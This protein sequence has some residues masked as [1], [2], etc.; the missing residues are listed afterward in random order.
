MNGSWVGSI[1]K[2]NPHLALTGWR[3]SGVSQRIE[4]IQGVELF[5]LLIEVTPEFAHIFVVEA[6]RLLLIPNEHQIHYF[7]KWLI[8]LPHHPL[9]EEIQYSSQLQIW[10]SCG[11]WL[12]ELIEQGKFLPSVASKQENEREVG[13]ASLWEIPMGNAAIEHGVQA[14]TAA[15]N[16]AK[17]FQ[18]E[19]TY[20]SD[21]ISVSKTQ[22]ESF[23]QVCA[24]L[25]IRSHIGEQEV[26]Q[27]LYEMNPRFS[28]PLTPV[29]HWVHAL[30]TNPVARPV[31]SLDW[32]AQD[33]RQWTSEFVV[34]TQETAVR[35]CLRL[36][37]PS[38][39]GQGTW[40]LLFYLQAEHDPHIML[41]ASEIWMHPE[42]VIV[43]HHFRFVEPQERLL[44][45]LALAAERFV[46]LERSFKV[47]NPYQCELTLEEAFVFLS[48]GAQLLQQEGIMV[49]VP[50]W[51]KKRSTPWGV[52]LHLDQPK[53]SP[54]IRAPGE[55]LLGFQSLV[56]YDLGIAIGDMLLTPEELKEL[57]ELNAPLVKVRGEWIQ[58]HP[59]LAQQFLHRVHDSGNATISLADAMQ[60]ALESTQGEADAS[61]IG[62]GQLPITKVTATGSIG[63]LIEAWQGDTILYN[64]E[65]PAA[66]HGTLR[67][68]QRIGY[69]WL[70]AM[71]ELGL[72]ACLADD[73]GLGKTIQ[74]ISYIVGLKESVELQG[75]CLLV[76]PTS[77]LENWKRELQQFAPSLKV[78]LH[79]GPD[80][81][82]SKQLG[83]QW[84]DIDIVMTSYT[85]AQRDEAMLASI[86]WEVVTLDEAQNIKNT[87][88]KQ[89]QTI[90]KLHG[91]HRIALTG[92]PVENRLSELWSIMDFLN[93]DYLGTQEEFRVKFAM[94]IERNQ[95]EVITHTLSRIIQPFILR[96]VKS[97]QRVIQDLPE[98]LEM[99]EFCSLTKE[100]IGLYEATVEQ[101]LRK[102]DRAE[103]MERK[104]TILAALTQ[105]KQ[106]CNHPSHYL[107]DHNP[108]VQRSGKM[109]RLI[110]LLD[111]VI[112]R[113]ERALIFTQYAQ[114]AELLS[115]TLT[116]HW[117]QE[118]LLITG[119]VPKKKRDLMISRFQEEDDAPKLFVLSL[120]TGGFGIN[121]TRANHVIHYDRW[122]NPAVEN[123]ATDRAYRIGQQLN[124]QVHKLICSGTLEEK[125]DLMIENKRSL[126]SQVVG[127]GEQWVTEMS[128]EQLQ[129]LFALRREFVVEGEEEAE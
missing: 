4:S 12:L 63:R 104:G 48:E 44:R 9:G 1:D 126:A 38:G 14:I 21:G 13:I 118:V 50:S 111:N 28:V 108:S 55:S 70:L 23:I 30:L 65:Q 109:Q 88:S 32:I 96:R 74:F 49:L 19:F 119:N 89:T 75:P 41:A 125:I 7:L 40:K 105:L 36:Q 110:E 34:K 46:P 87:A 100:Q 80:R 35:T 33:I 3:F 56:H 60:L 22:V 54:A 62:L 79:Y 47:S 42:R 94:P 117:G 52:K 115:E 95:D 129:D 25:F 122:W 77:V 16:E 124:V 69:S 20:H 90:R 68:Y 29:E 8:E 101:M 73:M 121:L 114:M 6:D 107:R 18:E 10:A 91:K 43:H 27:A 76:S 31:E 103:G 53:T 26:K 57:A 85:T 39:E 98:K 99:K 64:R 116:E 66:L 84:N 51:W 71:R 127:S 72:G 2:N 120:K 106:I 123:Q 81:L 113:G 15:F 37:E 128:T 93:P 112:V 82:T 97:D 102:A 67:P 92:T 86:P 58:F 83:T 45:D 78:W 61:V 59:K 5:S 17:P 24:D 11:Q